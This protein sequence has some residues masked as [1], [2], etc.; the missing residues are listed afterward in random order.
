MGCM[1]PKQTFSYNELRRKI[2]DGKKLIVLGN[3]IYNVDRLLEEKFHTPGCFESLIGCEV[4]RF[5]FGGYTVPYATH[6]TTHKTNNMNEV[7]RARAGKIDTRDTQEIFTC[8]VSKRFCICKTEIIS[9]FSQAYRVHLS[10]Y[11]YKMKVFL[12]DIGY[13]GKYFLVYHEPSRVR[14][15]FGLSLNFNSAIYDTLL[16]FVDAVFRNSEWEPLI[17]NLDSIQSNNLQLL[18][19]LGSTVSKSM[20]QSVITQDTDYIIDDPIGEGF[21]VPFTTSSRVLVIAHPTRII[22]WLDVIVYLFRYF[23]SQITPNNNVKYKLF[24]NENYKFRVLEDFKLTLIA[25]NC[26]IYECDLIK[27]IGSVFKAMKW[28]AFEY[29][30]FDGDMPSAYLQTLKETFSLAYID[31]IKVS[32]IESQVLKIVDKKNILIP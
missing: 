17:E 15:L 13:S 21:N 19:I 28:P 10:S 32:E 23:S 26:S 24:K 20:I 12:D 29:V 3:D 4:S 5:V 11:N 6:P 14:R 18:A 25:T 16:K 2:K 27:N 8:A 22:M 9:G 30:R 31:T 1:A 7:L